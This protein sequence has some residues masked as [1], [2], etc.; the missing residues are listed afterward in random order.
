MDQISRA[1]QLYHNFKPSK[2]ANDANATSYHS[3]ESKITFLSGDWIN[4]KA[5]ERLTEVENRWDTVSRDAR[6]QMF[7]SAFHC[8]TSNTETRKRAVRILD[9]F[10]RTRVCIADRKGCDAFNALPDNVTL[11]RGAKNGERIGISWTTDLEVARWFACES[12]NKDDGHVLKLVIKKHNISAVIAGPESEYLVRVK[13]AI[14]ATILETTE[15]IMKIRK[16]HYR[17]RDWM[18]EYG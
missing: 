14:G 2:A 16:S 8:A 3:S 10:D 4:K 5:L 18:K 15:Q 9:R 13:I 1:C 11:Y 6:E 7:I 17:Q 12:V